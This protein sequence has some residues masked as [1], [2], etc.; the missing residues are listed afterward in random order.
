MHMPLASLKTTNGAVL[1][2]RDGS[3]G[4]WFSRAGSGGWEAVGEGGPWGRKEIQGTEQ[5]HISVD[6]AIL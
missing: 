1:W 4:S 5:S 2:V 6:L 3:L